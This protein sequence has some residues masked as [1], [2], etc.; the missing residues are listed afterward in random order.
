[1]HARL[2]IISKERLAAPAAAAAAVIEPDS[3][4][5]SRAALEPLVGRRVMAIWSD[6][7]DDDAE[8]GIRRCSC[9]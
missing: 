1:M 3:M 4:H 6:P 2:G 7:D 8:P 9:T 5:E